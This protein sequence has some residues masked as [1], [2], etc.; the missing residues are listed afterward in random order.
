MSETT[1]LA[2]RYGSSAQQRGFFR[3]NLVVIILTT[4][5]VI[6]LAVWATLNDALGFGPRVESRDLAFTDLTATSVTVSFEVTA[7]PGHEVACALEAM[8]EQFSIVGWKVFVYPASDQRIRTFTET[9]KTSQ[10][11]T[12]GLVYQCWLT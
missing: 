11:P 10:L 6:G 12:T 9:I 1:V 2:D 7:S 8:N 4:V 5:L 3:R